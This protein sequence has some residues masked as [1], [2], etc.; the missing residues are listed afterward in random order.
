MA[1]G[2]SA[3]DF[4]GPNPRDRNDG[5]QAIDV[6]NAVD[7]SR[8]P[9]PLT[10]T[11]HTQQQSSRNT[12]SESVVDFLRLPVSEGRLLMFRP[13][14]RSSTASIQRGSGPHS[15]STRE[16]YAFSVQMVD[17]V[18]LSFAEVLWQERLALHLVSVF[19][20]VLHIREN[21]PLFEGIGGSLEGLRLN[22]EIC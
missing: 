19:R 7:I 16:T 3:G 11:R 20:V 8:S 18:V 22:L 21:R 14:S 12:S 1:R 2:H 4:N 9:G 6:G 15:S 17:L 5:F 10:L 13:G